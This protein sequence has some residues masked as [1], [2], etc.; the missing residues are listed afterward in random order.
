MASI[1]ECSLAFFRSTELFQLNERLE[2]PLTWTTSRRTIHIS[3]IYS[4]YLTY[5]D[6]ANG[7]D[8]YLNDEIVRLQEDILRRGAQ[9]AFKA[10]ALGWLAR[11]WRARGERGPAERYML[12]LIGFLLQDAT[13]KD[14]SGRNHM[15]DLE[16]WFIEWG[17]PEKAA[18]LARW[19]EEELGAE[20][21][22]KLECDAGN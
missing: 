5:R 18:E 7:M 22:A 2:H 12:E 17:E 14:S 21:T 20:V 15:K 13:L 9:G 16:M 8:P 19:R 10:D 3:Q 1:S 11:A 6:R 4:T